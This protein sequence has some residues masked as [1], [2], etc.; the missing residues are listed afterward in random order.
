MIAVVLVA[1]FFAS[2]FELNSLVLRL[3]SQSKENISAIQ[4]IQDRLETMRNL[5]F[6]DLTNA[7]YLRDTLLVAPSN[8]SDFAK[9]VVEDVKI[10]AY[11]T[12]GL[13]GGPVGTGISITRPAG[14]L[15]TPVLGTVDLTLPQA[16]AVLV[17]V[18]HSWNTAV[19][20]RSRSEESSSIIAAGLKK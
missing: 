4:G 10:V 5:A 9:K 18:K 6:A 20:G 11:D 15:V 12:S 19:L 1:T 13:L 7:N 2:I 16:D 3:I 8:V 17:T 14:T